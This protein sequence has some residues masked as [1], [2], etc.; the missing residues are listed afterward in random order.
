[1]K[2]YVAVEL[3][4]STTPAA[5]ELPWNRCENVQPRWVSGGVSAFAKTGIKSEVIITS[6]RLRQ[7]IFFIPHETHG[8][9]QISI[10]HGLAR[11]GVLIRSTFVWCKNTSALKKLEMESAEWIDR[12]RSVGTSRDSYSP[13]PTTFSYS[14]SQVHR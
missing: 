3:V 7:I 8:M 5:F 13:S 2:A 11:A 6:V 10:L 9:G 12:L 1:L 4:L 14:G